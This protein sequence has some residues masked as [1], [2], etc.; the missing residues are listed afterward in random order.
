MMTIIKVWVQDCIKYHQLP[1]QDLR[2]LSC[3]IINR[4]LL[5]RLVQCGFTGGA[6]GGG[7]AKLYVGAPCNP[8][9]LVISFSEQFSE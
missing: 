5:M 3:H 1:I 7:A 4:I 8:V 9:S 2:V 6:G